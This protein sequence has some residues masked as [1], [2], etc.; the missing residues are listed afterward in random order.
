MNIPKGRV[1]SNN[2][3]INKLSHKLEK[4]SPIVIVGEVDTG[5]TFFL[6]KLC[7]TLINNSVVSEYTIHQ[8]REVLD[9][10]VQ[11][12][13]ANDMAN[14]K[15]SFLASEVIIIEDFD[16]FIGRQN[17]QEELFTI[18]KTAKCPIIISTTISIKNNGFCDKLAQFFN[19]G[20]YITL[21][22]PSYEDITSR[23]KSLIEDSNI[24]LSKDAYE[25][26]LRQDIQ[27]FTKVK[28]I[29][30]TLSLYGCDAENEMDLYDCQ[31]I[32]K[33]YLDIQSKE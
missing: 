9:R 16:Y 8:S 10:M 30:K 29:V 19:A 3:L 12:L 20:T 26:L 22:Y 32:I 11:A 31:N 5:K 7:E 14:W 15:Q 4:Y 23:L 27:S 6:K 33:P 13:S 1:S 17:T 2:D 28:G 18:F 25:W 21:G 24:Y